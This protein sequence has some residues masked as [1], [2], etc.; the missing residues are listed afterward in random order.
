MLPDLPIHVVL[1]FI[2]ITLIVFFWFVFGL[3][4]ASQHL[5]DI[6]IRRN[7]GIVIMAVVMW[8][9]IQGALAYSGFYLDFDRFPPRLL[10]FGIFPVLIMFI[11]APF[12]ISAKS[13]FI[14]A[15]S[16]EGL[17]YIQ[18][19]R[20][21]VE[22]VLWW[23]FIY[24]AIPKLMTFEGRNFDILVGITA[25]LVGY[26]CFT[27]PKAPPTLALLWNY[28]G[29]A[30]LFNIVINAILAAPTPLQQFGFDQPNV[31]VVYFPFIWLGVFIVPVVYVAHII[32]IKRL[33]GGR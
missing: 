6:R 16:L 18:A 4:Q 33:S 2:L 10:V 22:I 21:P 14:R 25:P 3:F 8:L 24:G 26:Y 11:A 29:L 19:V 12:L 20:F 31:A 5:G 32:S 1:T 28:L 7:V 30:L 15:I 9:L 13:R 17:T 23:L 27:R